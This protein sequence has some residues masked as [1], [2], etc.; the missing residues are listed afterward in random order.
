MFLWTSK[1][2]TFF[3][4]I[5]TY[6]VSQLFQHILAYSVLD[7]SVLSIRSSR[8]GSPLS[9]TYSEEAVDLYRYKL[10]TQI[11]I[12]N[13]SVLISSQTSRVQ[14]VI[15]LRCNASCPISWKFDP[16]KVRLVQYGV[17]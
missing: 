1:T 3:I 9:Q 14:R 10:T 5:A 17:I 7:V 13:R 6:I 11:D 2:E 16:A 8:L 12:V 15:I 4:V